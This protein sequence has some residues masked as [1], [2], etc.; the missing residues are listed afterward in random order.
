MIST[1]VIWAIYDVA[2]TRGSQRSDP[3]PKAAE[4]LWGGSVNWRTAMAYDATLAI[5]QGLKQNN[6]REGLRQALKS[7]DFQVEG[8]TGTFKFDELG[9]RQGD[10]YIVRIEPNSESSFGYGFVLVP[11]RG[12]R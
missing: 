1:L 8:A 12:T 9:D 10:A 5:I 4:K 7:E 2:S 3:F 6:T 11:P